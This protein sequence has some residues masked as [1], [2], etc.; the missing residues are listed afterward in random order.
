MHYLDKRIQVICDQLK[1]QAILQHVPL[2]SWQY[3]AGNFIR[4][5]DADADSKPFEPFYPC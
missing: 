4:P 3:K 1:K 5:C 2:S